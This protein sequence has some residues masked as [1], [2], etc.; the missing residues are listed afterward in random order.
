[1]PEVQTYRTHAHVRC[2]CPNCACETVVEAMGT[3]L[4][5][6]SHLLRREPQVCPL[7]RHSS[8]HHECLGEIPFSRHS[9]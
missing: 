8:A 9:H 2:L 6:E 1:M 3:T 4:T 5:P 7:C